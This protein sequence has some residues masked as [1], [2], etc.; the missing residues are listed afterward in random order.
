MVNVLIHGIHGYSPR[1]EL[2][3]LLDMNRKE[4]EE[5]VI[6]LYKEGR[7]VRQIAELVHMSSHDIGTIINTDIVRDLRKS[8]QLIEV[9]VKNK[10]LKC[11]VDDDFDCMHVGFA[12]AL[13]ELRMA[14][15]NMR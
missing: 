12:L 3:S 11:I 7:T 8:G 14:L 9:H 13:P 2:A 6:R 15:K 5:C 4:R 1:R 10:K